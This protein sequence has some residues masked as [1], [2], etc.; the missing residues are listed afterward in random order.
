MDMLKAGPPKVVPIRIGVMFGGK[1]KHAC[2]AS[3][4]AMQYGWL[5]RVPYLKESSA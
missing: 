1:E 3:P 5:H 4:M 2:K